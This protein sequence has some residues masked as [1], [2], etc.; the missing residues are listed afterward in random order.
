M[1]KRAPIYIFLAAM[2]TFPA[3]LFSQQNQPATQNQPTQTA[4]SSS[5]SS[6]LDCT[7]LL[8]AR[9]P[10]M[11]QQPAT[12]TPAN[13]NDPVKPDEFTSVRLPDD[14]QKLVIK[15]LHHQIAQVQE[16]IAKYYREMK[17][18]NLIN[19]DTQTSFIPL[20]SEEQT[21][22]GVRGRFIH[23]ESGIINWNGDK[24]VS[25]KFDQRS[26]KI[27]QGYVAKKSLSGSTITSPDT[28]DVNEAPMNLFVNELLDSGRGLF[29]NFRFPDSI[30]VR[31]HEEQMNIEGI[32]RPVQIVYVRD[33]D[34][35][36]EILRDYLRLLKLLERRIDWVI[37]SDSA[38]KG[39]EIER[40]MRIH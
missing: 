25:F 34:Q 1:K 15:D 13:Q 12:Q 21:E 17:D 35:R 28:I 23:T 37:R 29:V 20:T 5:G 30:A 40:I 22:W 6:S 26:G 2:L 19:P 3:I 38:R 31:D 7:V 27:G 8:A 9:Y 36:I 33:S 10:N 16:D 18:R 24:I 11:R 32:T 39:F 14:C 4:A